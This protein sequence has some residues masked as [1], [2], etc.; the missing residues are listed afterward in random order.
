VLSLDRIY[1]RNA[2]SYAPLILPIKP[3]SYL[4]DHAPLAATIE[5]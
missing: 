2:I 1:V 5:L 4:S 3:W